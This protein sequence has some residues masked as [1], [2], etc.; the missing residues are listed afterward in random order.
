MRKEDPRND[1]LNS[2]YERELRG[3]SSTITPNML[4]TLKTG[5]A[6]LRKV[7]ESLHFEV[8]K[9][10]NSRGEKIPERK[11]QTILNSK[12]SSIRLPTLS[13]SDETIDQFLIVENLAADNDSNN[14]EN[15]NSPLG[16]NDGFN[17][18]SSTAIAWFNLP[19]QVGTYT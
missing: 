10:N 3:Q 6:E 5:I 19:T 9:K 14:A 8:T 11:S 15:S 2:S 13:R 12:N 1:S 16:E 17:N 4:L 7:N 18:S